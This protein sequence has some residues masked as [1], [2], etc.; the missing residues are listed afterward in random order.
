MDNKPSSADLK[1]GTHQANANEL[2]LMKAN[3]VV[4]SRSRPLS[5][6][7]FEVKSCTWTHPE[8]CS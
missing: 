7:L 5:S 4:A 6:P 1:P 2:A 8:N 3:C